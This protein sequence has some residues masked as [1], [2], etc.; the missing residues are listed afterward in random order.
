M[1]PKRLLLGLMLALVGGCTP[2]T[3][4]RPTS[5]LERLQGPTGP[6]VVVMVVAVVEQPAGDRYLNQELWASADEQIVPLDHRSVLEDNGFRVGQVAGI[7]PETL[8]ELLL[9]PRSNANP[10]QYTTRAGNVTNIALGPLQP[11]CS[12]QSQR[13]GQPTDVSFKKAQC[14]LRIVPSPASDGRMRLEFTP[15][16]VHGDETVVTKPNAER[17]GREMRHE[18]PTESFAHLT[19]DVTLAPGEF[20]VVGARIDKPDTLGQ[21]CFIEMK[22]DAAPVQRLLVIRAGRA[23]SPSTSR[24]A[25]SGEITVSDKKSPPLALQAAWST[26]RGADE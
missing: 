17:S 11:S 10:K 25:S 8:Q 20:I 16:I 26:V 13:D 19:W 4:L 2:S 5:W 23:A 15:Q 14:Q 21:R 6:D 3:S 1:R 22:E 7:V 9:S 18:Q 12:F 24:S